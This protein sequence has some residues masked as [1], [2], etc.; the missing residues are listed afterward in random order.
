MSLPRLE[1]VAAAAVMRRGITVPD[2]STPADYERILRPIYGLSYGLAQS[3]LASGIARPSERAW[4]SISTRR[5][6]GKRARRAALRAAMGTAV[7]AG[8]WA[9]NRL[10]N[11]DFDADLSA[12]AI[13]RS[14]I[15]AATETARRL[16]IDAAHV[17]T[18]HSHRGGPRQDEAA[19]PLPGGG[20][21]HNT[22]S[23]VFASAFHRPGTP[24]GPYW[25][26]TVTWLD[27]EGPPQRV[28][29]LTGHSREVLEGR[30]GAPR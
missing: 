18:G 10:L 3:S 23:W 2:P 16:Q 13:T 4:R 19:W 12:A 27:D 28:Q 21:L 25:P 5:G 17:I 26:G 22:G 11:A 9:V 29:L 6:S 30:S 1:C 24:P 15:A 20:R 8:V 14:G 7:P